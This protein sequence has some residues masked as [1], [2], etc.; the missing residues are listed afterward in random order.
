MCIQL[1]KIESQQAGRQA[2]RRPVS[3]RLECL[4]G[5]RLLR[6]CFSA[7][8]PEYWSWVEVSS[9]YKHCSRAFLM[10]VFEVSE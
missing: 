9:V 2:G 8:I 10:A 7:Q 6:A 5:T 3:F 1:H 4:K